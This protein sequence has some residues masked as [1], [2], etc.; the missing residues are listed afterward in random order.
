MNLASAIKCRGI[1]EVLHFTT[2]RGITGILAKQQILSRQRLPEDEYLE[3]VMLYNCHDR[4]RDSKWWDYINLSLSQVNDYLM[5]IAA[6]KWHAH[7]QGWW[8]II[9][10]SPDILLHEGVYFAT[11]NNAYPYVQRGTGLNAFEALFAPAIR[12]FENK[13]V[14]RPPLALPGYPTCPQAEVLYPKEM[15]LRHALHVYVP[16]DDVAAKFESI[17]A[18]LPQKLPC[19]VNPDMFPKVAR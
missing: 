7:R 12:Q 16:S 3:H 9:A 4:Q 13:T 14:H 17:S 5:A 19:K 10:L 18:V 15:S 2:H 11:T 6:G 1:R 8:C